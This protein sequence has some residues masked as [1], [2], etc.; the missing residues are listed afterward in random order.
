M[1]L[2]DV[3]VCVLFCC[4]YDL[5]ILREVITKMAGLEVS[6]EITDDQLDAMSGG[7]ILKQEVRQQSVASHTAESIDFALDT[8]Q[9]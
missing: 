9:R 6:E 8:T 7:D 1:L 5:L 4:S 2:C 3:T